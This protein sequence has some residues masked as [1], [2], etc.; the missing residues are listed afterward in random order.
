MQGGDPMR[1]FTTTEGAR[2]QGT[3]GAGEQESKGAR[4]Q[5]SKGARERGSAGAERRTSFFLSLTLS[6]ALSLCFGT[7]AQAACHVVTTNGAG[8]RDGS[9][10]NNAFAWPLP[11]TLVRGDSYY[12]AT[13]NYTGGYRFNTPES[14]TTPITIK[15]A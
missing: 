12:I 2:E 1:R 3:K 7:A 14:G 11:T 4:E 6:L 9:T 8:S 5:G 10:W 13:G 15:K